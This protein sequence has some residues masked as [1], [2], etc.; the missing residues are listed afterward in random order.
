MLVCQ[1]LC[2]IGIACLDGL[3]DLLMLFIGFGAAVGTGQCFLADTQD[4]L[5]EVL[6][7]M[8]QH[9]AVTCLIQNIMETII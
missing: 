3:H 6:Q 5:M 4:I 7:L 9:L 8:L 2:Q 1:L